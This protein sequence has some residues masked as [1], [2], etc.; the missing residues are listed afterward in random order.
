MKGL[1]ITT[2]VNAILINRKFFSHVYIVR[3]FER[4]TWSH[5]D[6]PHSSETPEQVYVLRVSMS[7]G[8]SFAIMASPHRDVAQR[9]LEELSAAIVDETLDGIRM[10][11]RLIY[12]TDK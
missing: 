1:T 10:T 2:N 7:N 12:W 6:D 8:D 9:H 11:T 3:D 5:V 4:G